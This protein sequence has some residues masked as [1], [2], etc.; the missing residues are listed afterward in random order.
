MKKGIVVYDSFTGNT[1]RVAEAIA[2]ANKFELIKVDDAPHNLRK[3]DILVVGTL[4]IRGGPTPKIYNFLK[5]VIPPEK[6]VLFL[7]FGL[8]LWGYI[9]ALKCLNNMR[10][11]LE[12]KK[13]KYMGKFI[14][15]GYHVKFKTYKNRPSDKD[16][17]KAKN[18]GKS[19]SD[20]K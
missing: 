18:F 4:N 10:K 11:Q 13:S 17:E 19:L 6:F 12:L 16:L 1:K 15:P 7:T 8:P 3:Y 5:N 2:S 9:T 14:C 20:L